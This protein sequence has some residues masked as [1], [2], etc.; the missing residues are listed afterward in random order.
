MN[1]TASVVKDFQ[2]TLEAE[3][4]EEDSVYALQRV[5]VITAD[6]KEGMSPKVRG[7]FVELE[8]QSLLIRQKASALTNMSSIAIDGTQRILLV[9]FFIASRVRAE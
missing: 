7:K 5:Q 3:E 8:M 6:Y 1:V 9:S 2:G 4:E